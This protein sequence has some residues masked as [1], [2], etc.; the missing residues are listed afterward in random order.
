MRVINRIDKSKL[1]H[2]WGVII[3]MLMFGFGL[4]LHIKHV[5]ADNFFEAHIVCMSDTDTIILRGGTIVQ[6]MGIDMPVTKGGN[7]LFLDIAKE[8]LA[9]NK[10]MLEGKKIRLE[11]VEPTAKN[12]SDSR[13]FAYVFT[14]GQMINALLLKKGYAAVSSTYSPD[15][16]Y[17]SYFAKVQ[18][19]AILYKRGIWKKFQQ[20]SGANKYA[21]K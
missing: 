2:V 8:A 6:F 20:S 14:G 18:N 13:K 9:Y 1:K 21:F 7:P 3:F 17:Q 5:C 16:K 15:I 10:K 12:P 11:F 19:E 4:T